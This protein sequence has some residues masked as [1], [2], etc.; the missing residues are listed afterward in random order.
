MNTSPSSER[1]VIGPST[2]KLLGTMGIGALGMAV[3]AAMLIVAIWGMPDLQS[4]GWIVVA[5]IAVLGIG[6]LVI[7]LGRQRPRLEIDAEGFSVLPLF[8]GHSRRWSDIEGDFVVIK[9][10]F[11]QGVAYRLTPA[12][13]ASIGFKP[14]TLFEGNDQAIMGAFALPIQEL[15]E[16]LNE[17]KARALA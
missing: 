9:C 16:L 7:A 11:T 2:A 10:G 5:V 4:K 1:L 3:G 13:K 6:N 15:A 17:H 14:T 12:Y 8:G